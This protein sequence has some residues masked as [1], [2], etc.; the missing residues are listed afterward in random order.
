[1][2]GVSLKAVDIWWA[3]WRAGGR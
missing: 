3:K 1:M 2:F